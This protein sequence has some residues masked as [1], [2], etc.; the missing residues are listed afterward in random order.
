MASILRRRADTNPTQLP[1]STPPRVRQLSE[2]EDDD[3]DYD[4]DDFQRNF[5]PGF[6]HS[7]QPDSWRPLKHAEVVS[8]PRG[9]NAS[10][11][12]GPALHSTENRVV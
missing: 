2:S 5:T 1:S 6:L 9:A 8:H 10:S 3:D 7:A 12:A 11:G 4:Y